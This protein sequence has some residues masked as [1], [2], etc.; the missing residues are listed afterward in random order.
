MPNIFEIGPNM[1]TGENYMSYIVIFICIVLAII[2]NIIFKH[3]DPFKPDKGF[4]LIVVLIVEKIDEMVKSLMGKKYQKYG[5]YFLALAT[6]IG[7]S[8]IV[9]MM[10][11][12]GPM[13]S[14][15]NTL[16]IGLV[17]FVLIHYTAAKANK[18]KY[19]NRYIEPIPVLLPINLLS[20]WAPLLS[21]SLRIFGN[22]L[23]GFTLMNIVYWALGNVSANIF[24][25]LPAGWNSIILAPI[26]TPVLHAYFD[27]FSGMIQT[28]IFMMLSMIWIQQEDPDPEMN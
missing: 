12:P 9:G 8:F 16:S 22:A 14:L 5:G 20:M 24:A 6:Y 17:T 18:W 23:A 1:F 21:I 26:I 7:L 2:I 25:F 10:G 13:T 15:G 27:A 3:K 4:A 28:L 19:F 11:L